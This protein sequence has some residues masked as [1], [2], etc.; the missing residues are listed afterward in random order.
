M[1]IAIQMAAFGLI[2]RSL[3]FNND[4]SW[5]ECHEV[6]LLNTDSADL[7]KY[8]LKAKYQFNQ[9]N[10]YSFIILKCEAVA[11]AYAEHAVLGSL[12]AV[13]LLHWG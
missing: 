5:H 1:T 9:N 7:L 10:P 13:N 2:K 12:D 8:R 11:C 6:L 3:T 4:T